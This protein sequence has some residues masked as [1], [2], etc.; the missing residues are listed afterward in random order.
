[1]KNS[2]LFLSKA[3]KFIK[4]VVDFKK[5]VADVVDKSAKFKPYKPPTT[6]NTW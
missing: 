6:R 2:D 3:N 5:V 1:V 4:K